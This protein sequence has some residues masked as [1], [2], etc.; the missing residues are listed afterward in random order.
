MDLLDPW[1][2][3]LESA[4]P[5]LSLPQGEGWMRGF[6][7][8]MIET[9]VGEYAEDQGFLLPNPVSIHREYL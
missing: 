2:L 3:I 1:N 6:F 9:E 8:A 7:F 4:A 5:Y